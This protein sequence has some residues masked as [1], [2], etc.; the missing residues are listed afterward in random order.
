MMDAL[1]NGVIE[2]EKIVA[3]DSAPPVMI[4]RYSRKLPLVADLHPLTNNSGSRRNCYSI[5][6]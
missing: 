1:M 2:S 6:I 3:C 4:F 5:R